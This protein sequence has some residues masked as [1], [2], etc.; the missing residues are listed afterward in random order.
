MN[1]LD[2]SE[3][4]HLEQRKIRLEM[5]QFVLSRLCNDHENDENSL[6]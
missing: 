6:A 5:Y 4:E 2:E 3:K 1:L